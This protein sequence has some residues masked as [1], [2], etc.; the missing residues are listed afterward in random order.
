MYI[1]DDG[2]Q[3]QQQR[4]AERRLEGQ[5]GALKPGFDAGR[6]TELK[7]GGGDRLDRIAEGGAGAD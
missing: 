6:Q 1:N 7:L 4:V 3:D 5:R 2:G